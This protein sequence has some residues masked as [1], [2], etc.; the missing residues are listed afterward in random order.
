MN[1]RHALLP[2]AGLALFP[3]PSLADSGFYIGAAAGGATQDI[4]LGGPPEIEEDDTA[5]KVF[6]GILA[7][8]TP[9]PKRPI[10][11]RVGRRILLPT[12]G[13]EIA[14][15]SHDSCVSR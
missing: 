8:E 9:S 12:Q 5:F 13:K 4:E 1:L 14:R 15:R 2:L 3:V 7:G 6:A 10:R 11:R